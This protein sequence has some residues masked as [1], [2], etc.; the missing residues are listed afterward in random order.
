MAG[1]YDTDFYHKPGDRVTDALGRV[2]SVGDSVGHIAR[3]ASLI[4]VSERTILAIDCDA[5]TMTISPSESRFRT[6]S[7]GKNVKGQ[8]VLRICKCQQ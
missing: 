4:R 5:G 6:M 3:V 2:L 8:N 1:I 7:P